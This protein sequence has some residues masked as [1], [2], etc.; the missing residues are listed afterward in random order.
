MDSVDAEDRAAQGVVPDREPFPAERGQD[1]QSRR[2]AAV[3]ALREELVREELVRRRG[4]G[5]GEIGAAGPG[6]S[7]TAGEDRGD[8]QLGAGDEHPGALGDLPFRTTCTATETGSAIA[9]R[10][11][12]IC[13]GMPWPSPRD[14][15]RFTP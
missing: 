4:V 3:P 6:R 15:A 13:S 12:G 14:P 2:P 7:G 8:V 10:A 1:E 9:P 5:A 11:K